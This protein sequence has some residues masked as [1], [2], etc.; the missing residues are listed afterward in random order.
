MSSFSL[1]MGEVL[2]GSTSLPPGVNFT[3]IV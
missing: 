1:Q 2:Y 3:N